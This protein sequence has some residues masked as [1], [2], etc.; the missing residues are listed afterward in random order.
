M[1]DEHGTLH[2]DL[3]ICVHHW[4]IDEKNFGTCKKCGARKHFSG[5]WEWGGGQR[6]GVGRYSK[7][8]KGIPA[9]KVIPAIPKRIEETH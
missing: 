8:Q 3:E 1:E 5:T 7:A 4:L 9:P 2:S 6:S